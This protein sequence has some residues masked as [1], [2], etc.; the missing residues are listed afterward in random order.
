MIWPQ[1]GHYKKA[2]NLGFG[3]IQIFG[4]WDP[5]YLQQWKICEHGTRP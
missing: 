5:K 4:P 1:Q 2:N 3:S